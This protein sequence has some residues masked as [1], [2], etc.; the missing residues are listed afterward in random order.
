VLVIV[1]EVP[2]M[3]T[4][5]ILAQVTLAQMTLARAMPARTVPRCRAG[6]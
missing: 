6:A 3:P 2:L 1:A 4:Q 5:A